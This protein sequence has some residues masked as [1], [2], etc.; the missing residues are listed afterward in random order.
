MR[1]IGPT[2]Q[3][4]AIRS[5][6][7]VMCATPPPI[8][9]LVYSALT[10]G[11]GNAPNMNIITYC[12]PVAHS[13]ERWYAVS[14]FHG[15]VSRDNFLHDNG[16][17]LQILAAEHAHLV[18]L[19]GQ[20]SSRD[21]DK[22]AALA[23]RGVALTPIRDH[24]VLA[25]CIGCFGLQAASVHTCGDHDVALCRMLWYEDVRRDAVPLTTG[26]LREAGI[27]PPAGPPKKALTLDTTPVGVCTSH[28]RSC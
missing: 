3:P 17:V 2:F 26:S 1:L 23:D 18:P 13:P 5:A 22:L 20:Q 7:L 27:L 16:G 6:L 15:T 19:L 12:T 24:K 14:L 8:D 9:S 10:S 25:G 28:E 21:V 4:S 11:A